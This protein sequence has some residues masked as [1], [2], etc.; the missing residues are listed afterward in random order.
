[1]D[2]PADAAPPG[3]GADARAS[4]RSCVGCGERVD[5]KTELDLVRLVLGPGEVVAV[6]AKGGAF[7]RGAHVHARPA[8]VEQAAAR[9]L[10]R[11]F[12]SKIEGVVVGVEIE[13]TTPASL[14]RAI[15]A[16]FDR[17]VE[18]LVASA[19][20]ARSLAFG[21]DAAGG[22]L[23][24]GEGKLAIVAV[25]AAAAADLG[26]VRAAV[27]AGRAVAWGTKAE[28]G[29]ICS[30]GRGRE[31]GVVAILDDRIARAIATA[32]QARSGALTEAAAPGRRRKGSPPQELQSDVPPGAPAR[33]NHAERGA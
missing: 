22:A 3:A 9:G 28:L 5:P 7:G 20:R 27:A 14:G 25:D 6:D 21:A 30:P 31:V 2:A 19:L 18:G 29:A 17:R 24:R 15:A 4:S 1:I 10:A 12:K 13:P 11:S 33:S 32:V 8:C 23:E 26:P 16:A